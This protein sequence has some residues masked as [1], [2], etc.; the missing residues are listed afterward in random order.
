MPAAPS[1]MDERCINPQRGRI[2]SSIHELGRFLQPT[3]CPWPL[4]KFSY[5]TPMAAP[6]LRRTGCLQGFDPNWHR[7]L[8]GKRQQLSKK[9]GVSQI[10][11]ALAVPAP[12]PRPGPVPWLRHCWH[13]PRSRCSRSSPRPASC[14]AA[15]ASGAMRAWVTAHRPRRRP[16]AAAG[17]WPAPGYGQCWPYRRAAPRPG[18]HVQRRQCDGDAAVA[19]ALFVCTRHAAARGA[20]GLGHPLGRFAIGAHQ[21]R[22]GALLHDPVGQQRCTADHHGLGCGY[23]LGQ[24]GN[25]VQVRIDGDH[26]VKQAGQERADDALAHGFAGWKAMSWRI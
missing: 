4:C 17:A 3:H 6:A 14:S 8:R 10:N 20:G 24:R 9:K 13:G 23:S 5:R 18:P 19:M 2:Q 21:Q 22:A 16:P 25:A 12:K 26:G 15:S 11:P 7:P 1:E